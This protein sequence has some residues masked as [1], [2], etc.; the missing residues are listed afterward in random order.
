[1]LW[2]PFLPKCSRT[3]VYSPPSMPWSC[4]IVALLAV[5]GADAGALAAHEFTFVLA[6]TVKVRSLGERCAFESEDGVGAGALAFWAGVVAQGRRCARCAHQLCPAQLG[7]NAELDLAK[8]NGGAALRQR[9]AQAGN[10][11]RSVDGLLAKQYFHR[12]GPIVLGRAVDIA[13]LDACFHYRV[14]NALVRYARELAVIP[15]AQP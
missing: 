4:A 2:M 10:R 1:M 3:N 8:V 7:I 6:V 15:T 13:A 11:R 5:L 12:Y 9:V 14:E